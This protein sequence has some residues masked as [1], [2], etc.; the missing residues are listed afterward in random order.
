MTKNSKIL[1][2]VFQECYRDP[3]DN[4]SL[5]RTF[6]IKGRSGK[7]KNCKKKTDLIMRST[8]ESFP[9]YNYKDL[10]IFHWICSTQCMLK[11]IGYE[12]EK[13]YVKK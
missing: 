11:Y 8:K 4:K 9:N 13:S 6:K 1:K 2:F 10:P 7:C 3:T 5:I 12:K